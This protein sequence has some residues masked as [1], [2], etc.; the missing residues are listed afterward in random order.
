MWLKFECESKNKKRKYTN[1]FRVKRTA[2]LLIT[3]IFNRLRE[4]KPRFLEIKNL[5]SAVPYLDVKMLTIWPIALGTKLINI[6]AAPDDGTIYNLW[7]LFPKGNDHLAAQR[8]NWKSPLQWASNNIL[9]WFC[10]FFR[11][12]CSTCRMFNSMSVPNNIFSS[13]ITT[14]NGNQIIIM[15]C[16]A[17]GQE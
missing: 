1:H 5:R 2:N 9:R 13:A 14:N 11:T 8:F 10:N 15:L 16:T 17:R 3:P 6:V 7:L 12:T 4:S